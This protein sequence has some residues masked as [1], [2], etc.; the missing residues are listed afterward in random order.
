[1]TWVIRGAACV[2]GVLFIVYFF[3][4]AASISQFVGRRVSRPETQELRKEEYAWVLL[5][6]GLI[7][8]AVLLLPFV[9][10]LITKSLAGQ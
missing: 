7:V 3:K 9:L 6:I 4:N 8:V 2:V 1:M 5:V 10:D